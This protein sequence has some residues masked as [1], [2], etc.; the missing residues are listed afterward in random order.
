[1]KGLGLKGGTVGWNEKPMADLV[2]EQ[3]DRP[4]GRKLAAKFRIG[5]IC[6]VGQD[7]PDAVVP[8]RFV[9]IAEHANDAVVQVHGKAGKHAPHL[10]VQRRKRLQDK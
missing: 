6:A 8:G 7:K 3:F 10:G 4:D 1:V 9:V 5:G 2:A